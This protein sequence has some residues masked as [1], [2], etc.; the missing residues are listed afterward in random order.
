[1]LS[2]VVE[3]YSINR[4]LAADCLISKIVTLWYLEF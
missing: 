4:V 1:M 3:P 2:I